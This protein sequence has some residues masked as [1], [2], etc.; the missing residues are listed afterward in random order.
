MDNFIDSLAVLAPAVI[1]AL[2]VGYVVVL[3]WERAQ[4]EVHPLPLGRMLARQ[5]GEELARAAMQREGT[6]F[7]LAIRRCVGCSST[8]SCSQ[9]LDAGGKAGYAEF[10]PNAE[11]IERLKT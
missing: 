2:I 1:I 6:A 11:F 5:G 7:A 4:G 8:A 9:W 3:L 10:C